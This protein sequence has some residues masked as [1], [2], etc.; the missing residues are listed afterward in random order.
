MD[1]STTVE[2]FINIR[3]MIFLTLSK[4]INVSFCRWHWKNWDQNYNKIGKVTSKPAHRLYSK[5]PE[6]SMLINKLY[7]SWTFHLHY[8]VL[9]KPVWIIIINNTKP[10][11]Y[12]VGLTVGRKHNLS[13]FTNILVKSGYN[14]I[15]LNFNYLT[16]YVN[17][18]IFL[19]IV[20]FTLFM[21]KKK[22]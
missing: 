21:K 1:S 9:L 13:Y 16:M 5:K 6:K 19:H 22:S 20:H 15:F 7:I 12:S 18:N 17:S 3:W 4:L 14:I 2:I 11:F 8:N 10:L